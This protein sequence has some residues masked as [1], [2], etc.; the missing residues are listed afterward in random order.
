MLKFE[1]PMLQIT[2]QASKIAR[3]KNRILDYIGCKGAVICLVVRIN[4]RR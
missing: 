4:G 1:F 3:T 2:L